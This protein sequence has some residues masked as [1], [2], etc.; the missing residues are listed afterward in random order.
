MKNIYLVGFMGTGKTVVGKLLAKKLN[1]KFVEMD[2]MIEQ[3]EH[4]KITEIFSGKGEAHFRELEK[5]LLRE[6]SQKSDLI[7]SC[8]GG[9]I[10]NQENARRLLSTG[11]VFNLTASAATIYERIKK[12]TSR[13]LLNV[14]DPL[15]EIE[16]LLSR[17]HKYYAQAHYTVE[18]EKKEPAAVADEII[19]L[20]GEK[21]HG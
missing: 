14:A 20:L 2:E 5:D 6:I 11:R 7:V 21:P 15:T 19:Q 1:K 9:L 18:S 12:H 10:C 13:P 17:R 3:K 8:G 16:Q 4:K